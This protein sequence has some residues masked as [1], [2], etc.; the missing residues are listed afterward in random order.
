MGAPKLE[1]GSSDSQ[2]PQHLVGVAPF[3]MGKYPVTQAQYEIIMGNFQGGDRPVETVSWHDAVEF[4]R[5]LSQLTSQQYRLPS[6]A[7]WEY[8]CRAGTTKPFCYGET[9]SLEVVNYRSEETTSVGSFPA[10]SYGLY[11]LH[12]NILKWCADK[13]HGTYTGAPTDGSAWSNDRNQ[14]YVLRGGCWYS[15]LSYCRSAA[16]IYYQPDYRCSYF[17]FRVVCI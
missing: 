14:A 8:A 2:R 6:E 13:Y 7:E 4:C 1:A 12:G 5:K 17:G 10:N 11:D 16:R 3:Y 15:R 9:I